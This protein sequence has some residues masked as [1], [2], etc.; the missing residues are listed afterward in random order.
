MLDS[1]MP[2]LFREASDMIDNRKATRN[3]GCYNVQAPTLL[4]TRNRVWFSVIM[5]VESRAVT[6]E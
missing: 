2:Y 1:E 6:Q 5:R 4:K 3:V